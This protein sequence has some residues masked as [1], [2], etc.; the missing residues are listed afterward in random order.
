MATTKRPEFYERMKENAR[1]QNA[2]H[3]FGFWCGAIANK[4]AAQHRMHLTALGAFLAGGFV[5][6][7][8]MLIVLVGLYGGR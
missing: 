6:G 7:L 3:A 1:Q 4:K 5:G 8:L 2:G